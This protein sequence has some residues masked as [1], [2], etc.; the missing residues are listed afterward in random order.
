MHLAHRLVGLLS[1]VS[2]LIWPAV[3]CAQQ[4]VPNEDQV[5]EP[6]MPTGISE[7]P[8]ELFGK[9]AYVW[10]DEKLG[11]H[12]IQ[13]VGDFSLHLGRRRLISQDAVVWMFDKKWEG[14]TYRRFDVYLWRDARIREAG[15]STTSGPVLFV[16]VNSFGK[17]SVDADLTTRESSAHTPLYQEAFR[18]R[19]SLL[20]KLPATQESKEPISVVSPKA[21]PQEKPPAV[22]QPVYV[23]P[24]KEMVSDVVD[25]ER[26]TTAIGGVYIAVG[27]VQS[28]EFTEI[29]AQ[30]AVLFSEENQ[31]Q[32]LME[33]QEEKDSKRQGGKE[34]IDITEADR[35]DKPKPE[36]T[37]MDVLSQT[38]RAA[39]LEGDVILSRGERVIRAPRLYY[40]FENNRALILDAVMFSE[41]TERGVPIYVR[42]KQIRQLSS[43]EFEVT[44]AKVTTSEFHTPHY[45]IGAEKLYLE[46]QTV[47]NEEERV[48][49][50][51]A[52]RFRMYD[53]TFNI[54]DT[55]VAYWPLAQGD[56]RRGESSFK[57]LSMGWSDNWGFSLETEWRL[58]NLLGTDTPA[59]FDPTLLLDYYSKR[60]PAVGLNLDY[61]RDD[62]F[63]L[64]R[65]Y[66]INDHGEDDL[67][68]YR[69]NLEPDHENRG[70]ILWRHRQYLPENWEL[71]LELSYI[72]DDNFL[73]EYFEPEFDEGKEQETLIY[74]KKQEDNWAFTTLANWRI[75]P[76]TT[77]TEHLPDLG[78]YLIGEP[79]GDLATFYNESHAGIVRYRGDQRRLF[80]EW[81]PWDNTQNSNAVPRGDTRNEVDVPLALGPVN[82]LPFAT[83]RLTWWGDTPR[84]S[85]EGRY[86]GNYGIRGSTYFWKADT[87]IRNR[88]LDVNGIRHIIKPDVTAWLSHNNVESEEVQPFDAGIEDLDSVDG[89][90]AGIRQRWQTKRGGPGGWRKVDWIILDLELGAFNDEQESDYTNGGAFSSRPENSISRNFFSGDFL[91][92]ISDSTVF[93][94]DFNVD[95]EDGELDIYNAS[96]AVERSPRFSYFYGYRWIREIESSLFGLGFN[97]QLSKKH[98][99]A[100]RDYFD[101][102]RGET[103]E[104]DVTYVRKLPRWNVGLTFELDNIEEDVGMKV[105]TWPEG[106]PEAA[107]GNRR[108]TGLATSTGIKP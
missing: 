46:D 32:K 104:F 103:A 27:A 58:F 44:K 78:F 39:Y 21:E 97:Y 87:D 12:I 55:P 94:S 98:I 101:L 93:L 19:Q 108:Y 11:A 10:Q 84:E 50:L 90:T 30:S 74:L 81:R 45:H 25:G 51:E 49:G 42:A 73:E 18:V 8:V 35:E 38:V 7:E 57:S 95:L 3:V 65:S 68:G 52:G 85:Q 43:R 99:L 41:Q 6:L 61:T 40:D 23:R 36:P 9:L 60:G 22:R 105:S 33:Q 28:A 75:L 64:F 15:G 76:F 24:G 83:Q 66:Y 1:G 53:T 37:D 47:R 91:Y 20:E 79:L 106:V 31:L 71:T 107:I 102:E 26:L 82:F 14:R 48:A 77:Q 100:M 89:V 13:Y 70:R 80:D 59:G 2:F 63:G 86:F 56:F 96:L 62:Y 5:E 34:T 72:S 67:G 16:T 4:W 88:L 54:E 69:D 29:R 92:R 17:T